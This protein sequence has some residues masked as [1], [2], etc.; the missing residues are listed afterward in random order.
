MSSDGNDDED[1]GSR[2]QET[3]QSP[4]EGNKSQQLL[5]VESRVERPSSPTDEW[6]QIESRETTPRKTTETVSDLPFC[7]S[8]LIRPFLL[9]QPDQ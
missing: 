1:F 5:S 3:P 6:I 9:T 4:A 7:Q 2:D 8:R